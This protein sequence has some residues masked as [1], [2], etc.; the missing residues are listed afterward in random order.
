MI[1]INSQSELLENN[2][3]LFGNEVVP[4]QVPSDLHPLSEEYV[5]DKQI[6]FLM[7]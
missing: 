5:T 2:G 7:N 1:K 6:Y 4:P 3:F